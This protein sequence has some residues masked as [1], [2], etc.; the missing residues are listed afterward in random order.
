MFYQNAVMDTARDSRSYQY[1][2]YQ[3]SITCSWAK[4]RSRVL[5]GQNP[6]NQVPMPCCCYE[7]H[8]QIPLQDLQIQYPA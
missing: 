8:Y 5:K 6:E 3:I 2:R 7:K 1:T 4:F